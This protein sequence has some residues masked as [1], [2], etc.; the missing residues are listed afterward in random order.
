MSTVLIGH[1]WCHV[2]LPD[3]VAFGKA[4]KRAMATAEVS[5]DA[6]AEEIGVNV[7]T[8]SQWRRGA[9]LPDP[10]KRPTLAAIL[11]T[12]ET[13]LF[14]LPNDTPG[15]ELSRDERV[16]LAEFEVRLY[17]EYSASPQ[18][19]EAARA[20][21]LATAKA[22]ASFMASAPDVPA[23]D[24]IGL[25]FAGS[26]VRRELERRRTAEAEPLS[27][28]RDRLMPATENGDAQ[29]DRQ[30]RATSGS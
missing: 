17:R 3:P 2:A 22:A 21:V 5:R 14:G 18:E 26:A 4:L 1:N 10:E 25:R 6:L 19:V 27:P 7:A 11:R 9:F 8:V 15:D 28:T 16:W 13:E 20:Y 24:L 23:R 12:T 30:R 29:T